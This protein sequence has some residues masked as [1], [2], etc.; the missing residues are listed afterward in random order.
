MKKSLLALMAALMAMCM[1][2][3]ACG[4]GNAGNAGGNDNAGGNNSSDNSGSGDAG[5]DAAEEKVIRFSIAAEPPTMDPQIKTA[6]PM[7]AVATHVYEGLTRV[8][9]GKIQPGMADKWEVSEDGKTYTFHIREDAKWHDGVALTAHDFEYAFLRILD[10][11]VGS[12]FAYLAYDIVGA[13]DFNSSVNTDWESVGVK[14]TDDHTLVITLKNPISYWVS[15]MDFTLFSPTRKDLVEKAGAAYG[16][17][18]DTLA[19]NGPY[20]LESWEHD[21]N[22]VLVKNPEYW[23]AANVTTDRIE[24]Y[25]ILDQNTGIAMYDSGDLDITDVPKDLVD[26]YDTKVFLDGAEYFIMANWKGMDATKGKL[27]GNKNF[28][29]ALNY[30][31]DRTAFVQATIGGA[32][33]PATRYNMPLLNIVNSADGSQVNFNEA[34]PLEACP[35]TA[36]VA[37]AQEYLNKALEETGI[38]KDAIPTFVYACRDAEANRLQAEAIQD[39]LKTNLGV[40]IE[41][42]QME[43]KQWLEVVNDHE[44]DLC[45]YG[46]GPDYDDPMTYMDLWMIKPVDGP[47]MANY[48]DPAYHELLVLAKNTTDAKERAEALYEAE[49]MLL[50]GGPIIPLYVRGAAYVQ[51][52]D[53]GNID[54]PFIG[55]QPKCMYATFN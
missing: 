47:N 39:M 40:N 35:A 22:L 8:F 7:A 12:E 31:I 19:F 32:S 41:I 26:A 11:A 37:K 45:L 54:R 46:W 25:V 48:D 34:Y 21:S 49:K 50:D 27:L 52:P 16:S 18:A 24:V 14:A 42:Q 20:I 55:G 23:D 1:L 13:E 9:N 5:N 15:F 38:S 44:Y 53:I 36:D 28:M 43:Y 29:Q 17:E 3:S 51:N 10:P 6:T 2:L 33:Q 4:G 30:A